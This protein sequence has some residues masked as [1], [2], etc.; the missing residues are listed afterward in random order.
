MDK[1]VCQESLVLLGFKF[2]NWYLRNH[3]PSMCPNFRSKDLFNISTRHVYRMTLF[4]AL[5]N[6]EVCLVRAQD[7]QA[8]S[9]TR[10]NVVLIDNMT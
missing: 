9:L 3:Q 2:G 5:A 7:D 1:S 8:Q 6:R 4:I 10:L